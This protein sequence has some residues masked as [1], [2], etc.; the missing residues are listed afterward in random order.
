M[1]GIDDLVG[2]V[3]SRLDAPSALVAQSMGG[4]IAIRVA[5]ARPDLVTHLILAATS[6]GMDITGLGA[7]D[8]RPFVRSDYPALPDWFLD[9]REDLTERL[10]ELPMPVLLLWGNSDPISPVK[11]GEKLAACLPRADL[12][13]F[14]GADHDLGYTHAAQ[15]AALIDRHLGSAPG[16]THF[17]EP[18]VP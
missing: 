5:L 16:S 13:I 2:K 17:K 10:P 4:I 18:Q 9:Y 15:V 14:D 8:W 1:N 7:Q 6:G 12:R 3:V 11:V